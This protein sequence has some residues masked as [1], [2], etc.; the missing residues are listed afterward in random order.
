MIL[1]WTNLTFYFGAFPL[2]GT[3]VYAMFSITFTL[4]SVI[5]VVLPILGGFMLFFHLTLASDDGVFNDFGMTILKTFAM[6]LGN[7]EITE[8]KSRESSNTTA[9]DSYGFGSNEVA[10]F[11]FMIFICIV[12]VNLMIGLTVNRI[13]EFLEKAKLIRLSKNY[14]AYKGF[15][16]F[17][18]HTDVPWKQVI[19]SLKPKRTLFKGFFEAFLI[20]QG[21]L[22]Q[23]DKNCEH[24][25]IVDS[26]PGMCKL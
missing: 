25:A 2:F 13:H 23:S 11:V 14:N 7:I 8:F 22:D 17:S 16:L 18:C 24:D 9:I 26:G 6:M 3:I 21:I 1:G 5:W 10:I 15:D 20:A 12:I 4:V 19:I